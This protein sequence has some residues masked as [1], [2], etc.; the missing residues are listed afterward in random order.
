MVADIQKL[1]D[2]IAKCDRELKTL[3]LRNMEL[4]LDNDALK[5]EI[6]ALRQQVSNLE[7]ELG[8]RCYA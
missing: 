3:R 4:S 5:L 8:E 6:M 1:Q 7:L 2:A